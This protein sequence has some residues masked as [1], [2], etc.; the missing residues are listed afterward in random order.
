MRT[1]QN[2]QEE[3]G[4]KEM[5]IDDR[6]CASSFLMF[7]SIEDPAR[8]FRGGIRP[9]L[10]RDYAYRTPV[11]DSEEL[12]AHLQETIQK[13][14]KGRRLALALSGGIDSAILARYMPEGSIAYTFKC[15]VPGMEVTDE[16][17]AAAVYAKECGLEHRIVEVYWEDFEALSETLMKHKG[18][19]IHSI[20]VQI[21]KAALQAKKDGIETLVFGENADVIY[22]GMNG[23]LSQDWLI[24][25]FINRYSYVLPYMV[26]RDYELVL[27]PF[28]R[29]EKDGH[30][31][32]HEFV[33]EIFRM[34]AMGTYSNATTTAGMKLLCP[35]ADTVMAVPM[36]Y[37]R[38]RSGDT[39]YLVREVFRKLYPGFTV[40]PKTPMPRPM[41]EWLKNWGGPVR[42]EFWPHCT[43]TMT[44]DQKWLVWILEKYFDM[45]SK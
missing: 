10:F 42:E 19:P 7:R 40:P 22:G 14:A 37:Q 6:Y 16:S 25:D 11:H 44:G 9:A 18:A 27:E 32:G 2:E 13:E 20:E 43:D 8:M 28:R 31:D 17:G 29:F 26:L 38:I 41:D 3:V 33:S 12:A 21:Y 15:V 39:K 34:E 36:D 23:L 4:R 35:Y 24:G 45:V 1:W 5:I 30:I